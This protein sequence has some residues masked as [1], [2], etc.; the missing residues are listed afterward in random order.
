[1]FDW[2]IG[3]L[4]ASIFGAILIGIGSL[5]WI[6]AYILTS[7]GLHG[8]ARRRGLANPWL[9]WIPVARV[10]LLG[11]M[12]NNEL[13][14]TPQL[15]I[16]YFQFILPACNLMVIFGNVLSPL[17]SF[18]FVILLI[19]AY[20]ALFRQYK[21]PNAIPYGLL[22]G[23]PVIAVIGSVFVYQLAEK[24]APDPAA[25]ATVFP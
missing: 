11:L 3:I 15:R 6:V 4:L 18:V 22:T 12:L 24:P 23:I 10:Y 9:A 7:I 13:A 25:D 8:A 5:A 16:P 14:V 19:M 1:M 2:T 17:F 20:I 21:E